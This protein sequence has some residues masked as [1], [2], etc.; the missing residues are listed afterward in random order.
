MKRGGAS[1]SP[2]K[3]RPL[4]GVPYQPPPELGVPYIDPD[5]SEEEQANEDD[6][7]ERD[8]VAVPEVQTT[9]GCMTAQKGA[10][11]GAEGETNCDVRKENNTATNSTVAQLDSGKLKVLPL[12]ET[13]S[14]PEAADEVMPVTWSESRSPGGAAS[15]EVHS[16]TSGSSTQPDIR[17][18]IELQTSAPVAKKSIAPP[19]PSPA[20]PSPSAAPAVSRKPKR[21]VFIPLPQYA[22]S[23]QERDL[24]KAMV[25]EK[26][27]GFNA[28]VARRT[29][30]RVART[31]EAK[32]MVA[33]GK[34]KGKKRPRNKND[35][36]LVED[37]P[38]LVQ[39]LGYQPESKASVFA[40]A[41]YNGVTYRIGDHVSLHTGD[42]N[43]PQWVVVCEGF[44]AS[45][46]CQPKFHGRWYYT[47]DD[48]L[49]HGGKTKV[50]KLAE[51]ER[52]STDSRD[53]NLVESISGRV[54]VLPKNAF[55][56]LH[57]LSP[58][59]VKGLYFCSN[60]YATATGDVVPIPEDALPTDRGPLT[61]QR[62]ADAMKKSAVVKAKSAPP[63]V[64]F[65]KRAGSQNLLAGAGR[66]S[67]LAGEDWGLVGHGNSLLESV[68]QERA[69][70]RRR[71]Q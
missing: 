66:R 15:E 38:V 44:Y 11:G 2:A 48:V 28:C 37:E 71:R 25:F 17:R 4:L 30:A 19:L 29:S 39:L 36:S 3:A 33:K 55:F 52:F 16:Y 7:D 31:E 21:P 46:D 5:A 62:R 56:K 45:H 35:P 59:L 13:C 63:P 53:Q 65:S 40:A 8:I 24:A 61:L 47:R 22:R 9:L 58:R 69:A 41:E 49:D 1:R 54:Y 6:E 26:N 42:A 64:R 12:A 18:W 50:K 23:A 60:F 51:Y 14:A 43:A 10:G 67:L 68:V 34:R 70:K 20:L 57:A 27:P 32:E